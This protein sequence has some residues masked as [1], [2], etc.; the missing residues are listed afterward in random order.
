MVTPKEERP[1]GSDIERGAAVAAFCVRADLG[2]MK[3][4]FERLSLKTTVRDRTT[5]CSNL[6]IQLL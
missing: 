4:C 1:V 3:R 5:F 6:N 2:R